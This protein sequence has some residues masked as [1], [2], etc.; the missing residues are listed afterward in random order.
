MIWSGGT[1]P[2]DVALHEGGHTFHGLADEYGGDPGPYP[3]GEP[4]EPNVTADPSGAKWAEWL[5]YD[6]DQ[7]GQIGT[8]EGG[9]Y[10]DTG[11]WRPSS[12]SKMN[13]VPARHNAPSVQKV[14]LDIYGYVRPIDDFAPKSS[15]DLPPAFGLRIVDEDMLEVDWEVD[16]DLVLEGGGPRIWSEEL[17]LSPG[18]H[19][20]AARVYDPTPW[21]RTDRS[22]LE[23]RVV[24]I[25]D[26]RQQPTASAAP[27]ARPAVARIRSTQ[28]PS[29]SGQTPEP[30]A[31]QTRPSRPHPMS[32]QRARV[33]RANATLLRAYEATLA[34]RSSE[35]EATL[36]AH[37]GEFGP[38]HAAHRK[39]LEAATRCLRE[40]GAA[41]T[42]AAQ[43]LLREHRVARFRKQVKQAC[44]LA[45][46]HPGVHRVR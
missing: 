14:V 40:P 6:Q 21:V 46:V 8:Y 22:T 23:Q 36:E 33:M 43:A 9:R 44:G 28:R 13:L 16:G 2:V 17:G 31:D 37:A 18:S 24:W 27:H 29:R 3:G 32:A 38:E 34:G 19:E 15:G 1:S 12:N 25:V 30:R 39:M 35:A 26:A 42:A 10:Y 20:V 45:R 11:I 41:S 7:I 5:G 4:A